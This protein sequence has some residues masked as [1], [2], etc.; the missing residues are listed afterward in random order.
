MSK[1]VNHKGHK[2][3]KESILKTPRRIQNLSFVPIVPV[4]V[5]ALRIAEQITVPTFV[6]LVPFVV[7]QRWTPA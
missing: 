1:N 4:M 2:G 6:S 5:N 3:H 7:T